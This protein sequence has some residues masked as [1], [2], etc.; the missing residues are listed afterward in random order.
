MTRQEPRTW[1]VTISSSVDRLSTSG[2]IKDTTYR[3]VRIPF[4]MAIPYKIPHE[5]GKNHGR[6]G[7]MSGFKGPANQFYDGKPD[8]LT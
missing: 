7:R 2:C 4:T 8:T 3:C 1:T 6:G 5:S